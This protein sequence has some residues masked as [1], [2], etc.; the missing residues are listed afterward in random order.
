MQGCARFRGRAGPSETVRTKGHLR[1]RAVIG[2]PPDPAKSGPPEDGEDA[3]P[4]NHNAH[5]QRD[6][7]VPSE[8]LLVHDRLAPGGAQSSPEVI[9]HKKDH[10]RAD[11]I[12]ETRVN[13]PLINWHSIDGDHAL[14]AIRNSGG[15]AAFVS[16]KNM[17]YYSKIIREQEGLNVL[18][19]STAGLITLVNRHRSEN[20]PHD[21][22]VAIITGRR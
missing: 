20:L 16:D 21:R 22:Y 4:G 18:P 15:F 10:R 1:A 14:N 5:D 11:Q 12:Q 19:A 2:R 9:R 3:A 13:E 8:S 6:G 7:H 17:M